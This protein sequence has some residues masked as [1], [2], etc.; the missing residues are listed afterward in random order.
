[1]STYNYAGID[2]YDINNGKGFGVTLFVQGCPHHC[3]GCHNPETWDFDGGSPIDMVVLDKLYKLFNDDNIRRL[4]FSGGEPFA[5]I[6]I[7]VTIARQFKAFHP[8]KKIWIYTG[9]TLEEL[10]NIADSG[11][12]LE[13]CDVLVDGP[14]KIDKTDLSLPFRGSSNQR[15][16]DMKRTRESGKII[17]F[18]MHDV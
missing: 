1:M 13:L 10:G 12:L 9:Y 17:L 6:E 15:I 7:C 16:I 3:N 5:N 18:D 4:T 8:E 2:T 11:R 14:F